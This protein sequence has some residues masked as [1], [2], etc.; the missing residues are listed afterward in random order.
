MSRTGRLFEL[1]SLL[2]ARRMPVT[3][4]YL[5]RELGISR[6]SVYRDIET[7]RS[8]GAPLDGQAGIG[9]R[10]GE[11]FFLPEFAFS[12]DELDAVILGLGWVRQRADPALAQGSERALAKILSARKNG[13]ATN[14][15]PPALVT[16]ASASERKDPPQVALL[17]DAIRRQHKVAISYGDTHGRLSDRT[18]WPIAIVY[19][20]D[21]RVLAAWCEHRSAFRHFRVDRLQ[22]RT[23]SEERY[24]G[25]RQSLAARWRQQDRDW[26]SMMTVSD[27][28]RGYQSTGAIAPRTL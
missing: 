12:S 18:V 9:Y 10:L 27:T 11:G 20:D 17:R 7:L 24:P 3:A 5:A 13:P 14:D 22:L 2:R 21:V 6:R 23:V 28:S 19:F 16:A 8:L 4:Q 15:A 25:R 1:I 26:R